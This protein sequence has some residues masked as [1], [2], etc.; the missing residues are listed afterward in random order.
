MQLQRKAFL[1]GGRY[2]EKLP[3]IAADMRAWRE[4]LTSPLGGGWYQ[5]EIEDLSGLC[6]AD[7]INALGSARECFYACVLFSGHGRVVKDEYGFTWTHISLNDEE[8]VSELDLNPQNARCLIVLDCCRKVYEQTCTRVLDEA[9]QTKEASTDARVRYEQAILKC[10]EGPTTVYATELDKY[11]DDRQSFT[12]ALIQAAH[13]NT[14]VH[15]DGILTMPDAVRQS[16]AYMS[17]QQM[18]V[19][20]GGRRLHHLPFAVL[21]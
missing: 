7:V 18:P 20:N 5:G 11:A 3:G 8:E 1:I 17:P 21:G 12:R 15:P 19:Y 6:R 13:G 4:F 14:D 9:V 2:E 10:E 16:Q